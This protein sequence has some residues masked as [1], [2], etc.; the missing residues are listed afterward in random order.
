[1]LRTRMAILTG[2]FLGS[3]WMAAPV[4]AQGPSPRDWQYTVEAF[5]DFGQVHVMNLHFATNRNGAGFG[6]GVGWRPIRGRGRGLGLEVRAAH[7]SCDAVPSG[8]APA[9]DRWNA[10]LVA[11]NVIYHFLSSSRVQPYL[12]GGFGF[13]KARGSYFCGNC[14]WNPDPVTGNKIYVED[15]R[16]GS[17]SDRG[18]IFGGGVKLAVTRHVFLRVELFQLATTQGTRWGWES[19]TV[20]MGVRF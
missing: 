2:V 19:S 1:M 13:M 15:R 4:A 8:G 11:A 7:I 20:G 3:V 6:G 5:G 16:S 10:S 18:P 12:L 17:G 14:V 9:Y